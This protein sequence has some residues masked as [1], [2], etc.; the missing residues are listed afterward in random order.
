MK[1]RALATMVLLSGFGGAAAAQTVF[2]DQGD[3]WTPALR[4]AFY[5]Q[6]Q[7]S[8]IMPLA[9][10]RALRLPDG[11]PFLQDALARYG[12]LPMPGR[13][14]DDLPV[15]FTTNGRG[16]DMAVG[17]TCAACHTREIEVN[18]TAYRVDGGPAMVDFQAFLADLDAAVLALLD[19][20]AAFDAFAAE[21]A[22]PDGDTAALREAVETWSLRFHTLMAR[23]LPDPAW[24]P[25]RLDAVSMIFNRLAGLDI[26]PETED[27]LIPDNIALA[28]APTRYPF[29]W[30]AARQ[31]RTQW[32]GFAENG[33]D[34]LGLARNLGEVY[35]VFG[36]FHP[37]TKPGLVFGHDY[38]SRNSANFDGLR[39][40]ED[41]VWEIGAPRWPWA[42]DRE[43]VR[44]GQAVFNRPVAAG[45]CVACH[46]KRRGERRALFHSTYATPILDV[47]TDTRECAILG[48]RVQTGVLEGARIPLLRDELGA[49]APAFEVLGVAVIGAIIQQATS[50]GPAGLGQEAGGADQADFMAQFD[51]LRGAFP[52]GA[53]GTGLESGE[54]GCKYAARVLEGIWAAAPYL[55]NGSVPSLRELLTPPE[56]RLAAYTPGPVYDIEAVGIATD[57]PGFGQVIETTG[58]AALDSGNSRCGHPYGTTLPEAEKRA[59]LEYLKSI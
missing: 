42:L 47:G 3:D 56:E 21:V 41:W 58:C 36:E 9:W 57:Q 11:A 29:L 35:G 4:D 30:N 37:A 17:M 33:N 40:L 16:A 34:L 18:G 54:T 48:R 22:G 1:L 49:E 43:L 52:M 39:A 38:I 20:A 32:P 15:G 27:Y 7:G 13:L 46:G 23:S 6:D 8:R 12:Y 59:L 25:G 31:D 50:F 44:Q 14:D 53:A 24:G 45:G 28:D 26:G 10:M 55:H 5:T 51:D 2:V 19:D